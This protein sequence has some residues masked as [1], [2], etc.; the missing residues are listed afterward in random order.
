[1]DVGSSI[2]RTPL[3]KKQ[4]QLQWYC[5]GACNL[6]F[7]LYTHVRLKKRPWLEPR[8]QYG[9]EQDDDNTAAT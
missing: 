8:E 6:A 3:R 7:R 5:T 4:T 9:K 1:M 2:G